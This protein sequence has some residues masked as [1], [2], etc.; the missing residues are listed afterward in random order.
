[1]EKSPKRFKQTLNLQL[2]FEHYYQDEDLMNEIGRIASR[3][4]PNTMDVVTLKRYRALL[5]FFERFDS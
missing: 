4:H 5:E 1:M 3:T 2:R